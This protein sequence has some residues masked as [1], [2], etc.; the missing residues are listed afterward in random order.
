M[1]GV[2]TTVEED[3]KRIYGDGKEELRVTGEELCAMI[4]MS[5]W[6]DSPKNDI[7]YKSLNHVARCYEQTT[8]P[9][10]TLQRLLSKMQELHFLL[11]NKND[12]ITFDS[13]AFDAFV[14]A[15]SLGKQWWQYFGER[16]TYFR[17]R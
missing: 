15:H 14:D 2:V 3:Y 8:V 13:K 5:N 17:T 4:A 6:F 10:R 16:A 9:S 12:R 1:G 11:I 7:E